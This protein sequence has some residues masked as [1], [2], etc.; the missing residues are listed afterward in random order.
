M[1]PRRRV[2]LAIAAI[3]T[4]GG[5]AVGG[6]ML[7]AG[8]VGRNEST[9]IN[10]AIDTLA[11]AD[12]DTFV[13]APAT[14]TWW[15]KVAAMGP[16][17]TKLAGLDP[18]AAGASI[19]R[20]GYSRSPD[21]VQREIPKTGPLRFIYLESP[22]T[23]DAGKVANW[24]KQADGFDNRRIY[25]DGQVVIVAPG[26]VS[27]Y[28]PPAQGMRTL[29]AYKPAS[30]PTEATMWMNMDQQ[31]PTIA[32]GDKN[33]AALTSM[34]H[35]GYGFKDGTTWI[36]TSGDGDTWKGSFTTGGVD[37]SRIDFHQASSDL[38]ATEKVLGGST[39]APTPPTNPARTGTSASYQL[40]DPGAAAILTRSSFR[41]RG[42]SETLGSVANASPPA[43]LG[44]SVITALVDVTAWDAAFSGTYSGQENVLTE[45]ASTSSTDMAITF[46]Y[47][48]P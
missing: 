13:V 35:H 48:K 29:A 37:P 5:F 6:T 9:P 25:Q 7:I 32:V 19:I 4:A 27:T 3:L 14:R 23:D 42:Q 24:L 8:A 43:A 41:V 12:A 21:H 18:S 17:S 22:T 11:P 20:I 40:I 44:D 38:H 2:T 10:S 47:K 31:I 39:S 33:S 16:F 36:G 26:W 1:R 15:T 45:A 30:R 34:L 46:T 28:Q